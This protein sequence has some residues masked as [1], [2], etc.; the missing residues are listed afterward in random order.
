[1]KKN[2]FI[3][4]I[5]GTA[6]TLCAL[7]STAL[8]GK[9]A[10]WNYALDSFYDGT[11]D[12]I[13]DGQNYTKKGVA[14]DGKPGHS[15]GIYSLYE[16]FGMAYLEDTEN[17]TIT[18]AFNSNLF[19]DGWHS[20]K[21]K[22]N[23]VGWGDFFINL[24][25]EK[26]FEEV[27]GT[28][29]LIAIRFAGTNDSGVDTSANDG[30]KLDGENQFSGETG[31]YSGATAKNL[32]SNN[33]GWSTYNKYKNYVTGKTIYENGQK[34]RDE[35]N[36]VLKGSV[37]LI[38]GM[39]LADAE[40]Y[41][42]D[43]GNTSIDSYQKK[44]GD[45][46]L[47]NSSELAAMGLDFSSQIPGQTLGTQTFGFSFTRSLLPGGS[48]EW[49]AHV[50]AECANDVMGMKGSFYEKEEVE[51]TDVPEPGLLLGLGVVGLA[52]QGRRKRRYN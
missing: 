24:N 4:L 36:Q 39:N 11:G 30:K 31:V 48:L 43:Y 51:N 9:A 8:P 20:K 22:D 27:Q 17:D 52:F 50:M 16:H 46:A 12:L 40:T 19:L 29:D 6:A 34:L 14:T 28:E 33:N 45:I 32:A 18:F 1:M 5:G 26:S 49:I 13:R 47:L 35:N 23:N 37:E 25:P 41:L 3:R 7:A 10:T 21:A 38:D 44:L 2:Y 15:V 42:G